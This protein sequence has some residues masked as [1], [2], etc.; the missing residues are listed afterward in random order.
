MKHRPRRILLLLA[1]AQEVRWVVWQLEG[2]RFECRG[3]LEQDT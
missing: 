3:V 1:V 2:C